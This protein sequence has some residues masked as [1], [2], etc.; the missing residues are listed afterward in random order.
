MP[1]ACLVFLMQSA[2]TRFEYLKKRPTTPNQTDI[3]LSGYNG[4]HVTNVNRTNCVLCVS[5]LQRESRLALNDQY[6]NERLETSA[7]SYELHTQGKDSTNGGLPRDVSSNPTHERSNDNS[8]RP[9]L[10]T[11]R[12][13]NK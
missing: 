4:R 2:Q 13:V 11:L 5:R 3:C 1:I 9:T 10:T 6:A 7:P 8:S 12:E